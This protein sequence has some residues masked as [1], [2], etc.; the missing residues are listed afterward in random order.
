MHLQFD[1][2]RY[3]AYGFLVYSVF[4]Q[5]L[6][7]NETGNEELSLGEA[8]K[9][10]AYAGA[11]FTDHRVKSRDWLFELI[12]VDYRGTINSFLLSPSGYQEFSSLSLNSHYKFGV[13]AVTFS[14]KHNLLYVAGPS[15]Q[16]SNQDHRGP[17]DYG[18]TFWRLLGEMPHYQVVP[19]YD[20][21]ENKSIS[22]FYSRAPEQDHI[23]KLE[24][25][26]KGDLMCALHASGNISIWQVPSLRQACL[27]H[28]EEQPCHDDM[29]PSMMQNPRLKK[30][31]RQ[32]LNQAIKW[33][34]LEVKW[35][36]DD[37]L[38]I[39]RYSGGVTIVSLNNPDRNLLGDSA[40]FFAGTAHLSQCFGKGFFV[41]EREVTNKKQR[42][43]EP[44]DDIMDEPLE[45][46]QE[47]SDDDEDSNFLVK[48]KKYA[49]NLAYVLTESERFAPPRK[50][51]RLTY[52]NYK[53][54]VFLST[55]PEELY[56]RKIE[57]EEYG[58]A[59]ILAQHYNLDSDQ[60]Y[61]R[62]WKLSNLSTTSISDYLTKIKRRAL[63][64]R[65]C[66]QTVPNDVEA[67]KALLEY[68]LQETDL[69]V[70]D[71]MQQDENEGR[72]VKVIFSL[73]N[74]NTRYILFDI[75]SLKFQPRPIQSQEYNYLSEEEQLER[76]A[77]EEQNLI[78]RI[79]WDNL[80]LR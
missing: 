61:E 2:F 56:S 77:N 9:G 19:P 5:R 62:Q 71:L 41:L 15:I 33:H 20:Y 45:F 78:S 59:L 75:L 8:S 66:L 60:V 37:S 40:E 51:P 21:T 42:K 7:Q 55:T 74:L 31:K 12:L 13:S 44:D 26:P 3:D 30:R 22:W 34:P 46:E 57:M 47:S 67:I 58:E 73:S 80:S 54:V 36:N 52:H 10:Y 4:S 17:S 53:L 48:T 65:E 1:F 24:E 27:W 18:L 6:P 38:V 39:S 68:G 70:L 25:S 35:W 28:L 16:A 32:F 49:K 14:F 50:R 69:H 79:N 76:K 43:L 11:F 23:F 72:F 29:N 63:V 64:L